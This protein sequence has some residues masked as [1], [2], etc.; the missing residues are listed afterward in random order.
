MSLPVGA[1]RGSVTQAHTADSVSPGQPDPD[2]YYDP[3][4]FAIDEDPY[5]VWKR[6]RD[7]QPLYYNAKYDFFA[8]SRFADVDACSADWKTYSSAKGTVL[9]LIKANLDIPPGSIHLRGPADARPAPRPA[10]PGVPAQC[11]RRPRAEGARILRAR[12]GPRSSVPA[13][14]TSSV[15]SAHSCRCA[16]SGC[17]SA[18]RRPT[19]RRSATT[20]TRA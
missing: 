6:L 18:S 2:V 20:S 19:R 5:P 9:E 3:Y 12:A 8:V 11:D 16:R 14:W 7:E 10:R 13:R 15:I 1:R 4:D 17:C